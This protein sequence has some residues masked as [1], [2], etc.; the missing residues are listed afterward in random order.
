MA[1]LLAALAVL[2]LLALPARAQPASRFFWSGDGAVELHHAHLEEKIALR[3]RDQGGRYDP[4]ALARIG[5][6][7][8][9]RTD[10]GLG[11]I[12]L[13][14]IELIDFAQD[15]C[16]AERVV[17]VSGYRSPE[18]NSELRTSG[19]GVAKASLHTQGMAADLQLVGCDLR[20]LWLDLRQLRV[21][22]VGYYEQDG[23]LHLDTGP[24]R[25]WESGTSRVAEN[26]SAGNSRLFARTD[27]D[28]YASLEGA[29]IS[30]H[31]LTAPPVRVRRKARLGDQELAIEPLQEDVRLDG[32]CY[33]IERSVPPIAFRITTD[34]TPPQSRLPIALDTCAP[35]LEATP[36]KVLSNPIEEFQPVDD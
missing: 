23:F 31:S 1:L 17:L 27:F 34:A 18:R 2:L 6:F 8:R 32:E 35:R 12:S 20:E 19:A 25:Y 10:N 14:L 21:G 16:S 5:H 7:F 22:G 4:T 9:S 28:R 29:V 11:Q 36:E 30:L 24:A 33:V 13:R 15:R 3:Y 26:L